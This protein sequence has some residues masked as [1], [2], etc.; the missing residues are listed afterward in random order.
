MCRICFINFSFYL[1]LF[2]DLWISSLCTSLALTSRHF[3]ASNNQA[4]RLN[5]GHVVAQKKIPGNLELRSKTSN[6]NQSPNTGTEPW[7]EL[8]GNGR[9]LRRASVLPKYA[10]MLPHKKG[11]QAP[12]TEL[13]LSLLKNRIYT[14]VTK[15]RF[16]ATCCPESPK[17]WVTVLVRRKMFF[18]PDAGS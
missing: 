10:R 11:E 14:C 17:T 2:P 3:K 5:S 6:R 4:Q 9:M 15:P 7:E 13:F 16:S 12:D 18:I 1:A 8:G